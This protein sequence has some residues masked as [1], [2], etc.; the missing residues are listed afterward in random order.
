L[1]IAQTIADAIIKEVGLEAALEAIDS[2]PRS[3]PLP[4]NFTPRSYQK[5]SLEAMR[6]GIKRALLV[7]HRRSGKDKTMLN[8]MI[9]ASRERIGSYYYFFPTYSQAKKV[10][11]AGIDR[12]GFPYLGH[13]PRELIIKKY[14][15][16]LKIEMAHGSSFQ[17]VGTDNIDSIMG[18]NPIGCVF[19]EY[20]LQN[21]L[22]WDYIRPI[23]R[24]NGG[25]AVFIYT[26]R[27]KN[28]GWDLYDTNRDN[29]DWYCEVLTVKDTKRPDGIPVITQEDIEADRREGM[30]EDL[31]EQEYYCSFE[32][33]YP[34]AY[35]SKELRDARESGRIGVVPHTSMLT[36]NTAWDLGIDDSMSIWFYQ[37]AGK[38]VRL[39]DYYE[40]SGEGLAHYRDIL[41][42]K[43]D[44]NGWAYK[45]H[46]APHDIKVRELGTGKSRLESAMEMGLKFEVVTKIDQKE[47][48]IEAV[49]KLFPHLWIDSGKCRHGINALSSFRKAYNEVN[50]VFST[51][52]VHDWAIHAADALQTLALSYGVE[53]QWLLPGLR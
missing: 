48:G 27:G 30:S 16:E 24:E 14:E 1:N 33:A 32:A 51:R 10:I 40:N 13:F 45:F 49:R 35:Y 44:A 9:E 19:S 12:D 6:S 4:H 8:W 26:P 23:L 43:A 52:P 37:L 11:W 42:Q 34:G 21:P 5:P 28:H 17:L 36:V 53:T 18:T 25:W 46:Y 29:P 15:T 31:I 38:E 22:A 39:V 7:W 50:K 47:D 41:K 20:S 3:I 2:D